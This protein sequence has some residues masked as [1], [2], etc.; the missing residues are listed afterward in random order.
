MG[1]YY[2]GMEQNME[3]M[4]DTIGRNIRILRKQKSQTLQ[5]LSKQIG[6]THQQLSRIENG[7]GT[8]T[9]TLER[10]AAILGVDMKVLIDE[11]EANLQKSVQKTRNFVPDQL[12]NEFYTRLYT[13]IIKPTNDIVIDKFMDDIIERLLK[14]KNKIRN[15]MCSHVGKKEIYQFTPS[16]LEEFCQLLFVDFADYTMRLSK[17][18]QEEIE[19]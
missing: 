17:V 14:D 8:S 4:K 18:E 12:C 7:S 1:Y 3:D 13:N 6:I 16:E 19:N 9:G 5:S 2:P 15:L 10:I 11:P